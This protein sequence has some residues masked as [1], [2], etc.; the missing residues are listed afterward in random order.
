MADKSVRLTGYGRP[1]FT[2]NIFSGSRCF[3]TAAFTS[4]SVSARTFAGNSSTGP[5]NTWSATLAAVD[6][7]QYASTYAGSDSIRQLVTFATAGQ[8]EISV[9]AV[10]PS[11]SLPCGTRGAPASRSFIRS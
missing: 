4:S 6:G 3:F 8:Y 5:L 10:S 2:V 1:A 7:Q 9:Y 11:G